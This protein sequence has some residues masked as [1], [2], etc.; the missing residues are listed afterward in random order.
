MILDW[1]AQ[2]PVLGLGAA[3]VFLPGLAALWF[4]GM[5]GLALAAFA[6]VVSVAVTAAAAI[7]YGVAGVP[8]SI[9]TWLLAVVVA[10]GAAALVGRWAP[11]RLVTDAGPT[12]RWVLPVALVLGAAFTTWRLI[13]YIQAPDAISQTN[14]AVFHLNALRFILET[15]DASSLHVSQVI[16]GRGFYPAAWHA[17]AALVAMATG[18][19]IAIV[20]N[21]LTLVIGAG[22]WTLGIAWLAL[23]V[24]RSTAVAALAAI[25]AGAL[26]VF[27]LLL[28]QWGVLYP[29]ALSTAMLPAAVV[30]VLTIPDWVGTAKRA[31]TVVRIVLLVGVAAVALLL[32]QP[33]GL[34]PWA[35]MLVVWATSQLVLLRIRRGALVLALL[36]SW[37]ALGVMWVLLSRSTSGSHWPPFRGKAEAVLDVLLNGH[38]RIPFAYAISA[39]MI[40]GLVECVRRVHLR[41]FAGVW[42][43]VS[44]LY[45]LVASAGRDIFRED[46]LGA[47]YA[48]PYR[49]S[50]LSAVVVIPLA[51]IGADALIGWAVRAWRPNTGKGATAVIGIA[52]ASVLMIVLV[53]VRPVAMPAV[54]Q[55]SFDRDSRYL[56]TNDSFLDP[57]ERTL[58]ERLD[59]NVPGDARVLANPSTGS[60]FGYMLSGIDVYP[61][62]WSWP[63]N[64]AW[65]TLATRL[66]FAA[67]DPEV[68]DALA[69]YNYP[70]FVLDFGPGEAGPGRYRAGGMTEFEGQ[71]GFELVDEVGD[72]SLWRITACAQ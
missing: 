58:L 33:S 44:A 71:A 31:A 51:A 30:V 6:P 28:F 45:V 70:E 41:W 27:P 52:A 61:R 21:M 17:L 42:L 14:D 32:S 69:E 7:V 59:E 26:Q 24:T 36:G 29:N 15:G 56:M 53:L 22:I 3:V 12:P 10:V 66:R 46:V 8:W 43:G 4:V 13:A 62:T 20:V 2:L 35:A 68:C 38:L 23:T 63:G 5:R 55:D 9:L 65:Q 72:V 64:A 1:V 11:G 34:L 16:G 49:I 60:G 47:W 25:L 39:L 37:L 57:D 67:E 18:V 54:T 40:V 48:D 50:A 19:E